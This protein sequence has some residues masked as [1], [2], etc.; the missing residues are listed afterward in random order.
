MFGKKRAFVH[1]DFVI[2]FNNSLSKCAGYQAGVT[3]CGLM[4]G[5]GGSSVKSNTAKEK[6]LCFF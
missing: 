6:P 1:H 5:S 4:M 3:S 2:V